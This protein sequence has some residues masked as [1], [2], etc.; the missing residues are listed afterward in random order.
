M[1]LIFWSY[2]QYLFA[3]K[4]YPILFFNSDFNSSIDFDQW[5]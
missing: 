1:I 3:Y 4:F 2:L 5:V